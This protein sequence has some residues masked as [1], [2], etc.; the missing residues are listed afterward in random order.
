MTRDD[1]ARMAKEAGFADGMAEIMGLEGFYNFAAL[2]A[3]AER[4]ACAK[5]AESYEPRCDTCPSGVST[6][7]RARGESK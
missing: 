4:E 3:V 5:I 1:I 2:V 7:I 6:A